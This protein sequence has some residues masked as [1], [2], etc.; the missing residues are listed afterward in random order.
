MPCRPLRTLAWHIALTVTLVTPVSPVRADPTLTDIVVTAR[1]LPSA[2]FD[3]GGSVTR[4]DPGPYGR[5]ELTHHS[6]ALDRVPGAYVQRGSGQESLVA[7]RSPVLSGAGAC[8]AFLFLEDGLPLRPAGFCNINE[9][10]EANTSQAGAIEVWRGPGTSLHGANAVHGVIN[11][12]SATPSELAGRRLQALLGAYEYRDV[13]L[14]LSDGRT[15]VY[16]TWRHDDG[17][18]DDSAVGERKVNVVHE[19]SWRGGRLR[20]RAALTDLDQD[21]AGFIRG[22]DAY[23][24]EARRRSNPNPEA[25]R[26]ARALRGSVA[27]ESTP[28]TDCSDEWRLLVRDSSMQFRQH[29]LL[30]KPLERNSQ[31]SVAVIVSR[32]RPIAA[33]ERGQ[34]HVGVDADLADTALSQSQQTPTLE[35]SDVARAIRPSG[36]H[37]DYDVRIATLGVHGALRGG[38]GPWTFE[39]SV[40]LDRSRYDYD[41]RMLAG[42]SAEDGTACPFGGCLYLRPED[43]RDQFDNLTP[44]FEGVYALAAGQR[45]YLVASDGF[46]PPETTEL[47]RLQRGQTPDQIDSERLASIELGWRLR[48]DPLDLDVAIYRARKRDLLLREANGLTLLG[49]RTRHEGIE[50][51]GGFRLGERWRLS[52]VSTWARHRY[53]FTRAVE[54]GETIVAGRDVDT[55]PRH[56]QQV[57]LRYAPRPSLHTE[58]TW[59]QVGAYFADAANAQRYPGHEVLELRAAWAW[60]DNWRVTL[61]LDNLTDRRYADRADFAQGDWR[62]FPARGRS[63]FIGFEWRAPDRAEPA[64]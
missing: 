53:D 5:I 13:R 8:G 60:R 50:L 62:Y 51:E 2:R 45:L 25:F 42:N 19:T 16:G 12:I 1:R 21:T 47:Y 37:Y 55:A 23:R 58:I 56:I 11:V 7:L 52:T 9:L 27:W 41:N 32:A 24:D 35:G 48:S 38:R 33:W 31:R 17:F 36:R 46:R 61:E 49:G 44:R 15:A 10:F 64:G 6:E 29:F 26:T 40:R 34:W 3:Q 63:L 22:L 43:R 14:S 57:A 4:L 54:G 28:C 20:W 59:Q 18:R 39:A 30:G